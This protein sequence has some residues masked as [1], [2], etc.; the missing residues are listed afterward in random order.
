MNKL[1]FILYFVFFA[2]TSR[3]QDGYI[4]TTSADSLTGKIN[5][6]LPGKYHDEIFIKTDTD[7][8]RLKSYQIKR[9]VIGENIYHTVKILDRYRFMLLQIG[10]YASLYKYRADQS[11]QFNTPYLVKKDG[12]GIEVPNF[13]FKKAIGDFVSDC[14]EVNRKVNDKTY[15]KSNIE[16]LVKDYNNCIT[17]GDVYKFDQAQESKKSDEFNILT[18]IINEA[19]AA[20]PTS[21]LVTLL[22]DI[23]SKM[24]KGES[25][26]KY[27][28]SA[29]KDQTK[30]IPDLKDQVKELLDKLPK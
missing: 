26:P 22:T 12:Y 16:E 14:E 24:E 13:N 30:G 23:K 28:R 19:K 27:L 11:Y 25:I 15:K 20:N 7:K 10:G 1:I 18:E 9:M 4:I 3:A 17:S 21:E 6:L 8:K 2:L 29:L 5:L